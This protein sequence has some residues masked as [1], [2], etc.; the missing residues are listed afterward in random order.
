MKKKKKKKKQTTGMHNERKEEKINRSKYA[1]IEEG[2]KG[3]RQK[4]RPDR[5]S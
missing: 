5:I 4:G 1:H 3:G 2:R